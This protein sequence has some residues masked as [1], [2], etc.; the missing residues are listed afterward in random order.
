MIPAQLLGAA[1]GGVIVLTNARTLM[2]SFDVAAGIRPLVYLTVVVA[3]GVAFA[4]ALRVL[5]R[6]RQTSVDEAVE[7]ALEPAR[8]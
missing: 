7:P 4:L 2:R 5:R 8:P 6:T 1:V 3:W